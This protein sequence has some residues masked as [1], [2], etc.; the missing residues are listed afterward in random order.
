M[1][2]FYVQQVGDT[3][4]V[5]DYFLGVEICQI[6]MKDKE[7]AERWANRIAKAL[8]EMMPTKD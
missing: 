7:A 8:N 5:R 6:H 3:F 4:N 1:K 2:A